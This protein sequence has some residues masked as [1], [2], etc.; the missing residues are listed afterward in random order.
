ME[1]T[2]E[3]GLCSYA[4]RAGESGSN[5][6]Q[7]QPFYESI[8][9]VVRKCGE[10]VFGFGGTVLCLKLMFPLIDP[11]PALMRRTSSL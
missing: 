6:P 3:L 5:S 8:S 11:L 1:I 9:V 7:V 4:D 10:I 2:E